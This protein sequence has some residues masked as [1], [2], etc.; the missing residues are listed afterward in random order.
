MVRERA[1]T[2]F[3]RR[4]LRSVYVIAKKNAAL[5]YFRPPILIHG[6]LLPA[7]FFLVF[8]VARRATTGTAIPG[9]LAMT[10]CFTASAV[11]PMITPWERRNK[12]YERLISSPVSLSSIVLGDAVAGACFGLLLT[13]AGL[14]LGLGLTDVRLV[15]PGMLAGALVLSALCFGSLG[16]LL[17][18]PPTDNP[19]QIM[20][21]SNIV[22]M[23]L[24][25]I[26][27]VLVPLAEMP[28]WSR[29]LVPVSPLSY[30]SDLIRAAFGSQPYFPI[31][32]DFLAL[33]GFS[34]AFLLA[35]RFFHRRGRAR[36]L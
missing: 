11:G 17:S 36:A 19:S 15:H 1:V 3:W 22:R 33:A 32:L 7:F 34:L 18:A 13:A 26:S 30:C 14:A 27:G 8:V 20:M 12:T 28:P 29:G 23:P 24:I 31:W 2:P 35:A 10:L 9:I 6:M 25:F 21:L 4:E 5:Y 16:V